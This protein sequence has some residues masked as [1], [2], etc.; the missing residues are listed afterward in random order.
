M[1][2]PVQIVESSDASALSGVKELWTEYCQWAGLSPDFQDFAGELR[3]LPGKYSRPDGGLLLVQIDGKPA[4]TAAF[5]PL[6]KSACEAKRLYVRTAYRRQGMAG[7][8]LTKLIEEARRCGYKDLYGDTLPIMNSA[9]V[10]YREMGFMEVGPYAD[11]PTPDAIYMHL[12][13]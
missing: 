5:R 8:L 3:T 11:N 9:L 1:D 7:A 10:L 4:G 12:G 6:S 2:W 13:L